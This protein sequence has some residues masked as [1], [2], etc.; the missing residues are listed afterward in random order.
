MSFHW[1][2]G[3]IGAVGAPLIWGVV[4]FIYTLAKTPGRLLREKHTEILRLEALLSENLDDVADDLLLEPGHS[5]LSPE[6]R[7][8]EAERQFKKL[9]QRCQESGG[10]V[11][12]DQKKLAAAGRRYLDI[13]RQYHGNGPLQTK[14]IRDVS[15]ALRSVNKTAGSTPDS[16]L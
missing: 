7:V 9:L 5:I 13:S 3:L 2:P 6:E 15:E 14:K 1:L 16:L 11:E 12:A 8:F 10:K 4:T